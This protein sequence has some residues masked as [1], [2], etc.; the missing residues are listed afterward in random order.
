MNFIQIN[1]IINEKVHYLRQVDS[2]DIFHPR[3][4]KKSMT[5]IFCW[6]KQL[7]EH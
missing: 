5:D 6:P 4:W 1:K 2:I 7:L 3:R